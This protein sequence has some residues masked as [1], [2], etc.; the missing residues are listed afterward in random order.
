MMEFG[1]NTYPPRFKWTLLSLSSSSAPSSS[2]PARALP[3]PAAPNGF[4]GVARCPRRSGLTPCG[5]VGLELS[6]LPMVEVPPSL[7]CP[8]AAL[9]LVG[10]IAVM[11]P[12]APSSYWWLL[13]PPPRCYLE[14]P[15]IL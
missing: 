15:N 8:V 6:L 1:L 5:G 12:E 4:Y 3:R 2:R 13:V 9:L 14:F 10:R 7:T 11:E